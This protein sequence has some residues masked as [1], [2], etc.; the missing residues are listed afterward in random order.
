MLIYYDLK[1]EQAKMPLLNLI[2]Y[3]QLQFKLQIK[4]GPK[5]FKDKVRVCDWPLVISQMNLSS[6]IFMMTHI[7]VPIS[8]N[9][10]QSTNIDDRKIFASKPFF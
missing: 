2:F 10:S 5:Y 7:K 1:Q 3:H 6:K 4:N 8:I 9:K